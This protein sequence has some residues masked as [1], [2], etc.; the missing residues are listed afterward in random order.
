MTATD[1][2]AH[3]V[4]RLGRPASVA[5][6]ELGPLA[7]LV[8]TW[9]G[10]RGFNLIALPFME[11]GQETFRLLVRPYVELM[12]FEPIGA[13]VPDRGGPS[14]DLF[15][16]GLLYEIR[17][18]D[19]ETNEPMHIENGMW[20][21]LG[22]T[23]QLPI[24]RQSSIPH[25]DVFMALGTSTTA[26]GPP[27]IPGTSALPFPQKA[28]KLPVGYTDAYLTERVAGFDAG[29][30]PNAVLEEAIH[31]LDVVRT[32]TI[33][34]S[35]ATTA[36]VLGSAPGVDI[37]FI[38]TNA[39]PNLFTSTYWIETVKDPA[40]E[41][42]QQL[43]YSQQTNINFKVGPSPGQLITWPHVNVNTLLKQ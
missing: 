38:T 9:V 29:G 2:T 23:Q 20:L 22:K 18:A 15:I 36:K 1:S 39:P 3:G 37:P 5:V 25:G 31:G 13:E 12:T 42:V 7:D 11:N 24:V 34:V 19:G 28:Q 6:A 27:Q 35:T 26:S 10:S 21:N 41:E 33:S 30:N 16:S 8:G 43:Q 4:R 40:G 17:I 32:V 14:G